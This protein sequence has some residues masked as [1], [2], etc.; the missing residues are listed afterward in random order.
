LSIVGDSEPQRSAPA[1]KD[2]PRVIR[3]LPENEARIRA[4]YEAS[5]R[6]EG[7]ALTAEELRRLGETGEWPEWCASY[8]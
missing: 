2:D 5:E 3:L 7:R 6:D 4:A 1:A 8:D